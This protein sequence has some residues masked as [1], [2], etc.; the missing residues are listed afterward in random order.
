V[1]EFHLAGPPRGKERVKR[2]AAGHAYTPEKTVTFEGRLAYAAQQVMG[3]RP[4]LDGPLRLDVQLFFAVPESWPQKRRAAALR[5]ELLPT[6]KPDWDN[7]GKLTD[8]LNQIVWIDD[9]QIVDG[10]VRKAYSDRPR[11]EVRVW[12][13]GV[14]DIFD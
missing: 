10:R 4:P 7:G 12:Q 14:D 11:T 5:G 2:G 6:V 9:R 3:E 1:I 13:V 8:A